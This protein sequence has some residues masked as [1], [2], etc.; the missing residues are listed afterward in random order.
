MTPRMTTIRHVHTGAGALH[1]YR[2][3][4]AEPG[5]VEH[6][7][8]L[9]R[10]VAVAGEIARAKYDGLWALPSHLTAPEAA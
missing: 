2:V 5:R 4:V 1:H 8:I 6:Y 7:D 10:S 3:T 9:A